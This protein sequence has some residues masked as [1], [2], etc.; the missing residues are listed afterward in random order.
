[1]GAVPNPN[2]Y[3]YTSNLRYTAQRVT[4]IITFLFI[5]FH[6]V[7]LH[8]FFGAPFKEIGETKFG[9]QFDPVHAASSAAVALQPLWVKIVYLIGMLSAIYHFSNGVWTLGITW[10]FWTSARAQRR[11]S[12]ISV[13]LGLF[14]AVVGITA[15]SGF[16]RVNPEQAIKVEDAMNAQRQAIL[17]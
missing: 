14:L 13:V 3:T 9:A 12:W 8:H 16:S 2:A 17:K 4:A 6:V 1:A 7:Q 15:L 10:G 5:A 11:A